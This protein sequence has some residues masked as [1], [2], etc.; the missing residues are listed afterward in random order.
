VENIFMTIKISVIIATRNRASYLRKV[1][2]SL[3]HQTLDVKKYEIIV[4]DNDSQDETRQVV[5]EFDS[6]INLHYIFE[7]VV[8]LS[9]ARNTGWKNAQ[10]EYIAFI[11]DDATADREWLE[12]Y[13]QAFVEFGQNVGLMGGKVELIWEAPKPD[14]LSPELLSFLSYYRYGDKPVVLDKE[15][16]LS[17]CNLALPKLVLMVADGFREDLGRKGKILRAGGEAYLRHQINECGLQSIY[18]P[19]IIVHHH[20]TPNKLTKKWF[21]RAAYWQGRSHAIM[22]DAFEK[23]LAFEEKIRL[24]FTRVLW[25]APRVVLMIIA[26]NPAN[27]FRRWFQVIETVGFLSGLFSKKE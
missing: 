10:G 19:D 5:G 3:V 18:H 17:A 13:I 22:L 14:W 1:I 4:V 24:S 11:D 27:R 12:R 20:V 6:S 2:T 15:Q 7:P 25:I 26:T 9:R 8:G 16:W 21:R 23:P